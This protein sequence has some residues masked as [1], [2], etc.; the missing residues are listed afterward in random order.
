MEVREKMAL[1]SRQASL[2]KKREILQKKVGCREARQAA[3]WK[4]LTNV[5]VSSM[6]GKKNKNY[7][8]FSAIW[9]YLFFNHN[10]FF[11]KVIQRKKGFQIW[12]KSL[13][14]RY[15]L[16]FIYKKRFIFLASPINY[17]MGSQICRLGMQPVNQ[18]NPFSSAGKSSL[19]SNLKKIKKK[20]QKISISRAVNLPL[21]A[22]VYGRLVSM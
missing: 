8:A 7:D 15:L 5:S 18:P 9:G 17:Y 14:I 4:Y 20:I 3:F 16:L 10:G 19:L 1:T 11:H 13:F 6:D 21:I 12:H 22:K 2:K